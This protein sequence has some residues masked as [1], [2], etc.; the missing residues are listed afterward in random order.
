[1]ETATHDRL[2]IRLAK[3]GPELGCSATTVWRLRKTDPTF[4][5]V[6][7]LGA[8][9]RGVFADELRMWAERRKEVGR[10]AA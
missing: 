5:A 7:Q 9:S 10:R 2:I 3:V 1:M 6:I 8:G 4:P